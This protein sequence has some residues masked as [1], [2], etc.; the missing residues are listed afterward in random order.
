MRFLSFI[1]RAGSN[2]ALL[3]ATYLSLNYIEHY[4]H[5]AILAMVILLYAGMRSA[6]VLRS[7]Q[8]FGRIERLEIEMRRLLGAVG[9]A[10]GMSPS[11]QVVTDVSILRH[12]GEKK[13]YI[14]LFFLAAIVIICV[15]KIVT[16]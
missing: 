6:S 3:A 15:S 2:F 9:E 7:F 12:D 16:N 1:Y 8:F 14:D 11:R 5:R 10:T 4:Q 13:A